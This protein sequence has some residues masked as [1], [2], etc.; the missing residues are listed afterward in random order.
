MS[1]GNQGR[2]SLK[3]LKWV[4]RIIGFLASAFFLVVFIGEGV[5][6]FINNGIESEM[7]FFIFLLF[8]AIIGYAIAIKKEK[9]GG[10]MQIVGGSAMSGYH[11]II[12][13]LKDFNVAIIFGLPFIF[14]GLIS[15][16]CW[17]Y[18]KNKE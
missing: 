7:L 11:L 4:G 13:G 14:S 6:G 10:I 16:I 15:M 18:N 8:I 12:G 3:Y 2:N 5:P 17:Y 1:N 9:I